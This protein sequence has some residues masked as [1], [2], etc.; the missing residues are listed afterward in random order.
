MLY[1]FEHIDR[2]EVNASTMVRDFSVA[3]NL[4]QLPAGDITFQFI[5][6]D[7]EPVKKMHI[8]LRQGSTQVCDENLGTEVDLY[9]SAGSDTFARIWF[10]RQ[11]IANAQQS[12][13]LKVIGNIQL[14]RSIEKW[15]G[16]SQLARN[17]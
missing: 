9:L 5:F 7:E 10:G 1:S 2:E 17:G 15:L 16:I 4:E 14:E 13:D 3:L 8:M 12:G 11:S 6:T